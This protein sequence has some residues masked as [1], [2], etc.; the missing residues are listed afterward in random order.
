MP[1]NLQ[2]DH[3]KLVFD[4]SI[5]KGRNSSSTSSASRA[6]TLPLRYASP[7]SFCSRRRRAV[8]ERS[9]AR[10]D[11]R[12]EDAA[13]QLE[14]GGL[15]RSRLRK[16]HEKTSRR[17]RVICERYT[18]RSSQATREERIHTPTTEAVRASFERPVS[19]LVADG[20]DAVCLQ[21]GDPRFRRSRS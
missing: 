21:R 14:R 4:P 20:A 9:C 5:G 8:Q 10:P 1:A 11:L 6:E 17:R 2:N 13:R 16:T 19:P 3:N 15:R 18:S 12:A 7:H